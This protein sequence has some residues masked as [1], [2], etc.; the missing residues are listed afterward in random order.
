MTAKRLE[1]FHRRPQVRTAK[2]QHRQ[3]LNIFQ[4]NQRTTSLELIRLLWLYLTLSDDQAQLLCS[5]EIQTQAY[6]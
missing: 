5:L 3:D 2:V 4:H 6:Y 1:G